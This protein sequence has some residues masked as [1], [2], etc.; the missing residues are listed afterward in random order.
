MSF[1]RPVAI[2]LA[3]IIGGSVCVMDC[4]QPSI[5][6]TCHEPP[7]QDARRPSSQCCL[8]LF[9]A[10]KANEMPLPATTVMPAADLFEPHVGNSFDIVSDF[11]PVSIHYS[12]PERTSILRI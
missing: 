6:R 2:L 4:F 5:T 10:M 11:H 9:P 8:D 12:P 3:L 1:Q 7:A